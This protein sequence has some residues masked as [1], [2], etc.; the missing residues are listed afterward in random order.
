MLTK[1]AQTLLWEMDYADLFYFPESR[2]GEKVRKL[3]KQ[4]VKFF[5]PTVDWVATHPE[6]EKVRGEM[7]KILQRK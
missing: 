7:V 3:E 2:I 6:I 4:G 5:I 1:E